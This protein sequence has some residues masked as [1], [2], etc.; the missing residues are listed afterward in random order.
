MIALTETAAHEIKR[1][2][3]GYGDIIRRGRKGL[4]RDSPFFSAG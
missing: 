3:E 1:L 4:D 2:I